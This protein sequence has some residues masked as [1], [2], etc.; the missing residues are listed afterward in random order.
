[1]MQFAIIDC[2]TNTF[3]LMIAEKNNHTELEIIYKTKAV[4]KLGEGGIVNNM[5]LSHPFER[6]LN[7]LGGFRKI[8]NEYQVKKIIAYGTAALRNARNGKNKHIDQ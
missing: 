1:M 5:I 6:G 4:V 2:G 8:I 7:A 3:H